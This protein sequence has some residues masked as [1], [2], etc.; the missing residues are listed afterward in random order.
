MGINVDL[1]PHL[2]EL[3]RSKVASGQYT[4]VSEVVGEALH[5]L[6]EQDR[7]TKAKLERLRGCWGSLYSAARVSC[8]IAGRYPRCCAMR[9][10][11]GSPT[12][13]LGVARPP[14][15]KSRAQCSAGALQ[16]LVASSERKGALHRHPGEPDRP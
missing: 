11:L 14:S 9:P 10:R 2:E 5:L 4:S 15:P 1:T 8:R 16:A 12:P 13:A 6:G 7:R 3:A